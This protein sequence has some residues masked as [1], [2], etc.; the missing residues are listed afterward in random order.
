MIHSLLLLFV[1]AAPPSRQAKMRT[2]MCV[3]LPRPPGIGL[4]LTAM[5]MLVLT[6]GSCLSQTAADRQGRSAIAPEQQGQNTVAEVAWRT[7]LKAE[8]GSSEAYAHLGFLAVQQKRYKEAVPVYRK[9]LVLDPAMPGLRLNLGLSLFKGGEWKEAVQ[10]FVPLLNG[11]PP[12]AA[13]A[14]RLTLLIGMGYDG[15]RQFVEAVPYLKKATALGSQNLP[16]RI[17]LTHSCLGSKQDQCVLDVYRE[18]LTLN[19]ESAEADLL[20]GAAL[21][22]MKEHFGATQQFRFIVKAVPKEPNVHFGL[23]YR[24]WSQSQYEEAAQEFQA[25]LANDPR[26][27]GAIAYLVN[28]DKQMNHPEAARPL[29]EQAIRIAPGNGIASS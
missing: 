11:Q 22:Q 20:A 3:K 16:F 24:L 9:A 25:K 14:Q 6:S 18:I 28:T 7:F 5:L 21:D 27:A 12:S 1:F 13:D 4:L 19:A 8:P 15:Q 23:R 17:V 10:T 26:A 29:L 2:E